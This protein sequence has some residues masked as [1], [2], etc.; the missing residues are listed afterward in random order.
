MH[1]DRRPSYAKQVYVIGV[2]PILLVQNVSWPK[3]AVAI[4][5]ALQVGKAAS[6]I[7]AGPPCRMTC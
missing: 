5:S 1:R 2:F 4:G 6:A 3:E 7:P